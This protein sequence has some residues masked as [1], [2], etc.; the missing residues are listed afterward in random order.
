M[1]TDEAAQRTEEIATATKLGFE[2]GK[3]EGRKQAGEEIMLGIQKAIRAHHGAHADWLRTGLIEA[4]QIVSETTS[5]P[6]EGTSEPLTASS[7]HTDLP[8]DSQG[9]S[10]RN[11][12][13]TTRLEDCGVHHAYPEL[14]HCSECL[15]AYCGRAGKADLDPSPRIPGGE[16]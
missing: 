5:Q 8:E 4:L 3:A 1:T 13:P 10:N 14:H 2:L 9:L 15:R 11:P 7:G 6:Q 12:S 16:G